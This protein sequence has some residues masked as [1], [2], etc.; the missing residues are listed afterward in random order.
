MVAV[1]VLGLAVVCFK[2]LPMPFSIIIWCIV[3]ACI[4][5]MVYGH[6][7]NRRLRKMWLENPIDIASEKFDDFFWDLTIINQDWYVDKLLKEE[8]IKILLDK[9]EKKVKQIW[10]DTSLS[11]YQKAVESSVYAERIKLLSY[12]LEF[13]YQIK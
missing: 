3:A 10:Q 13:N 6:Y 5:G 4:G 12:V 11:R 9:Y 8:G 2:F 7:R 1:L